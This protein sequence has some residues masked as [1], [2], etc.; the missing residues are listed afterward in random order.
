MPPAGS[1]KTLSLLCSALAW[2]VREKQRIEEGLASEKAAAEAAQAAGGDGIASP[3]SAVGS[4][5]ISP[6]SGEQAVRSAAAAACGCWTG[7]GWGSSCLRPQRVCTHLLLHPSALCFT[8]PAPSSICPLFHPPR[9]QT[10]PC[11]GGEPG[12]GGFMPQGEGGEEEGP[13]SGARRKAPK[14]FYATRTHSQIAQV[15]A[16]GAAGRGSG[17][18][19]PRPF[20][21]WRPSA[22]SGSCTSSLASTQLLPACR[23]PSPACPQVVKELKRSEYRPRMAVLV[24]AAALRCLTAEC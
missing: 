4:D 23:C 7:G 18:G 24:G 2:Q 16:G 22:T 8:K 11:S 6:A 1:G 10:G 9:L 20:C 19:S 17:A 21:F 5:G 13:A 14:I 3:D 12:D 15:G